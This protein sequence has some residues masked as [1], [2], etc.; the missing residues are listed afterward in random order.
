[1]EV[2]MTS[3][4]PTAGDRCSHRGKTNGSANGAV[5]YGR[6]PKESQFKPGQSGNSKGRPKG[7]QNLKTKL[8]ELYLGTV[9]VH[10]GK[11]T[12]R[13]TMIEAVHLKQLARAMQGD[14]RA[15]QAAIA[16]AKELGV[17]DE[18]KTPD[19]PR[20]DFF[21]RATLSRMSNEELK[22]VL[23]MEGRNVALKEKYAPRPRAH[24]EEPNR[25]H[26]T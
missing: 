21:T 15:A 20:G 25:Q 16:H 23:D 11:S 26:H 8:K 19:G 6:P 1:M 12:C 5:G 22:E 24:E 17:F 4:T 3:D 9:V 10:N 2:I 14:Y 7:S 18:S 13:V